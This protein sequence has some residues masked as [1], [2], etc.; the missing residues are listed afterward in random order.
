V[1]AV[2]RNSVEAIETCIGAAAIGATWGSVG[3]DLGVDAV[4]DRFAPLEPTVLVAHGLSVRHG[5]PQPIEARVQSLV[6]RLPSLRTLVLLDG[7]PARCLRQGLEVVTYDAWTRAEP[8]PIDALPLLPFDH[9]LFVLF[10]SG[11]TGPPKCL[12]HGAGGTLLEHVKEHRLHTDLRTGERLYFHTSCGW[13]MWNWQLSALASGVTLV[14]YDGSPSWPDGGVLL[15]MLDQEAVAVF[16]TS[17]AYVDLLQQSAVEPREHGTFASL[18]AVLSTGSILYE[19]H[20]DWIVRRFKAVPVQSI[21]GGSDIIGCFVL[22]NPL[23]PVYRGD[24]QSISLGLDVRVHTDRGIESTGEGELVCVNPFPSRPMALW[25]DPDRARFR[26][27]YFSGAPGVWTHGDR[28]RIT[29]HGSVRMLGRSD[30]TMNIRGVRIGPAE[31][32]RAVLAIPVVHQAMAIEQRDSAEPGRSRMVLLVVLAPGISLER[33]LVWRIKREI[34]Q[35]ASA[36]HVPA[37]VAQVSDLPQTLSGKYS[38]RAA[39]DVLNGLPSRNRHALRN[40]ETL[41]ELRRH[42]DLQPRP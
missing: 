19:S 26:D 18:R 38:E 36:V 24:S 4:V 32:Y 20:F 9:P 30:A 23:R 25:G 3:L 34:E 40:P 1:A 42:P 21:S 11:T 10:S 7:E 6:E 5:V 15:R 16:G 17:P 22:G 29:P 12:V 2:V 27:A 41:D 35:K 31:V 13:M 37:V 33:A 39:R 8:L 14:V 28:V